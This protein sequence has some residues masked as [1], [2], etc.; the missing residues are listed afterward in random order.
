MKRLGLL[1][2]GLTLGAFTAMA[3]TDDVYF[4]PKKS[5]RINKEYQDTSS[6]KKTLAPCLRTATARDETGATG[7]TITMTTTIIIA[8]A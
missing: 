8:V 2:I 1:A 3:Q 6:L 7:A 4:V 5:D